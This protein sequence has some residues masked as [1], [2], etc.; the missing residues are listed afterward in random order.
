MSWKLKAAIAKRD[1]AKAERIR[2]REAWLDL[3]ETTNVARNDYVEAFNDYN[4]AC[5]EV[6]R[7]AAA[8]AGKD[9]P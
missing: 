1:K 5:V 8:E 6:K 2:R 9:K 7:I 3:C 4:A